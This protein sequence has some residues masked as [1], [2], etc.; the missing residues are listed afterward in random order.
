MSY[1]IRSLKTFKKAVAAVGTAVPL[2]ATKKIVRKVTIAASPD[3]TDVIYLGDSTV[4]AASGFALAAGDII[5]LEDLLY[6]SK[7]VFDLNTI[8]IDAAIIAEYVTVIYS[9]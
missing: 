4:A 1:T 2:S 3:N 7:D 9:E 8:Y 6:N 5:N